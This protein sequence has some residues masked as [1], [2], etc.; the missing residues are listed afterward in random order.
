[1]PGVPGRATLPT[2]TEQSGI[3]AETLAKTRW[4]LLLIGLTEE[5]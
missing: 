5:S 1:M 2:L 3:A 4:Q